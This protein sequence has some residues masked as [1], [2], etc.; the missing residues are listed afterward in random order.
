MLALGDTLGEP[1]RD[2][3]NYVTVPVK[4]LWAFTDG[5]GGN[6]QIYNSSFQFFNP[7]GLTYTTDLIKT[8]VEPPIAFWSIRGS[9]FEDFN[10]Y[11]DIARGILAKPDYGLA[12]LPA[13]V[14]N[15]RWRLD[16]LALGDTLGATFLDSIN[17]NFTNAT[18][19]FPTIH[20]W[21][22]IQGDPTLRLNPI[23]PPS[24]FNSSL[25]NNTVTINWSASGSGISY[26]VYR[27]SSPTGP[28]TNLLTPT[29]IT[30][31][32]YATTASATETNYMVRGAR[33]FTTGICTYTNLS[34]GLI[35]HV[36]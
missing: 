31:T 20:R 36:P 2:S 16:Y 7:S 6:D 19:T 29:P 9:F 8:N 12:V 34:I 25:I 14:Q 23:R 18:A 17:N 26:F 22:N 4:Y 30:T 10:L 15:P 21:L 1:F 32:S 24:N 5:G 3:S 28:F 35:G 33:T 11:N 27:S 13:F